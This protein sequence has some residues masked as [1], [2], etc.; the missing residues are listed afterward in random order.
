MERTGAV[1]G[2]MIKAV[3]PES[4]ADDAGF[5]EGCR[6][7]AVD[8]EPLRDIIDWRW[9]ASDDEIELSYIDVDGDEG[10]IVL[11]RDPGEDWGFEF[12]EAVFDKTH[13]CR[14]ACTFCFMRQLPKG[15]RGTL[16]MRDDDFRLS[17]LTGTFVTLTNLSDADAKRIIEQRISPLRVSL[18]AVD[19][20]VRLSLIGRHAMAGIDNLKRLLSAG[21]EFD[22]QIVLVPGVND[23]SVLDET[24]EWAYSQEGIKTVGIVPL[25]F[26]RYQDVFD[27]SFDA[28]VDA[29]QVISQV[30]RFQSRALSEREIPWVYAADEFYRNAYGSEML[31][32]LPPAS[33]YGDFA[34]YED[35][36]G[37]IRSAVDDFREAVASGKAKCC[38]DAL[39]A[40]G[41]KA[42]IVCGEAMLP[43]TDQMLEASP[44]AGFVRTLPVKNDFFGGNVNVTGLLTGQ[45]IANAIADDAACSAHKTFYLI[46]SVIFN[47][48]GVT[49]DDMTL[50]DIKASLAPDIA[51]RVHAV[52]P[53]PLD[54]MQQITDLA[55]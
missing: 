20:G 38:A 12:T 2:A 8:G 27:R 33:F 21:I 24:L 31:D 3:V 19:P 9:L 16:S 17:F 48:D 43:Y 47:I 55:E 14:N 50:D 44:C 52:T 23:G 10:V 41:M 28:P 54:Y 15:M 4:P 34:M 42:A 25:G 22:A 36:I 13:I 18:H 29:L 1:T 53:N 39:R 11:V 49:L 30:E 5:Y 51:C 40:S 6:L 45:D 32:K 46:P 26:T 37:I 35:G 7:L